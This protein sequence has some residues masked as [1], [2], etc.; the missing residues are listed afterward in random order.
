[1]FLQITYTSFQ[2][3]G[4]CQHIYDRIGCAYNAPNNAQNGT[5]EV[6]KGDDMTP[7]GQYVSNG[8]TMTWTQVR[9]FS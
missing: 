1:M 5:F 6:C 3:E 8:V 4:L 7:V 9:E 2:A